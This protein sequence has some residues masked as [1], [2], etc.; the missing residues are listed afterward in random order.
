MIIN[1]FGEVKNSANVMGVIRGSVEPGEAE[2]PTRAR[3]TS[4]PVVPLQTGT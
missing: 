1:N 4:L 2:I 3:R